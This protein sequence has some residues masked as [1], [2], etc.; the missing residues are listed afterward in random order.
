MPQFSRYRRVLPLTR[1]R[2]PRLPVSRTTSVRTPLGLMSPCYVTRIVLTGAR[3][4]VLVV[5][6]RTVTPESLFFPCVG[7]ETVALLVYNFFLF[8]PRASLALVALVF[9]TKRCGER[10]SSCFITIVPFT[11]SVIAL[12]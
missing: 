4:V 12:L 6:V 1:T 9:L 2:F 10:A 8:W 7:S 5:P 11:L 3:A